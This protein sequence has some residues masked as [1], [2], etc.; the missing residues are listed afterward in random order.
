M[1]NVVIPKTGIEILKPQIALIIL[2]ELN[3]Q[4]TIATG[5]YLEALES[6]YSSNGNLNIFVDRYH[7]L[8]ENE[9]NAIVITATRESTANGSIGGKHIVTSEFTIDVIGQAKGNSNIYGDVKNNQI[10]NRISGVIKQ[11]LLAG[12]YS[13]LGL[14]PGTISHKE[15]QTRNFYKPNSQDANNLNGIETVLSVEYD[16]KVLQQDSKILNGNDSEIGTIDGR[17]SIN[18]NF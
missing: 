7:A 17:F 1:I 8:N 14:T 4:K 15:V 9:L 16:E 11:I 13:S 12:E 18:T 6:F 3:N 10:L 2:Q 5:D